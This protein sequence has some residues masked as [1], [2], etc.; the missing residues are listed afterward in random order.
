[1]LGIEVKMSVVTGQ[2]VAL[3]AASRTAAVVSRLQCDN[4][5]TTPSPRV[6][7][8]LPTLELPK[9]NGDIR[10]FYPFWQ[11][12]RVCVDEQSLPAVVKFCYLVGTLEGEAK[13]TLRGL[14]IT[15]ENYE[16]AKIHLEQRYGHK[17]SIIFS[18]IQELLY[19]A[20][21]ASSKVADLQPFYDNV[22]ANVRSLE[23]LGITE[24]QLEVI[25][26]P[27]LITK[28]PEDVRVE[29]S[30]VSEDREMDLSFAMNFLQN[31]VMRRRMC[32]SMSK[33]TP[34]VETQQSEQ[35]NDVCTLIVPETTVVCMFCR[36]E[37]A[38]D[39]CV[40]YLKK[41][42]SGRYKMLRGEKVVRCLFL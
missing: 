11:Q 16:K 5:N 26:T 6:P 40:E 19:L 15:G 42:I 38:S 23:T 28:L 12:F 41:G 18:H 31:E 39:R 32:E 20:E 30:R 35:E 4:A 7:V 17:Q 25:L 3:E 22:V 14:P 34:K 2:T 27:V 36:G 13:N 33:F 10:E 37:H 29:W 1:M 21:P 9:F 24:Q 8:D